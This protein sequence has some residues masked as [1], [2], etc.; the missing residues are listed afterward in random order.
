MVKI[1]L[2]ELA[3]GIEGATVSY[4]HLQEG[5][6]VMEGQD[7]VELATDKATFSVPSPCKGKIAKIY[8][9]EGE[10]VK[11]GEVLAEIQT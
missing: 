9:E 6:G 7:I 8:F 2:P 3:E 1:I 4:W 5:D 11:I 10:L